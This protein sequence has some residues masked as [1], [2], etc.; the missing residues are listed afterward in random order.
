MEA[1]QGQCLHMA[2]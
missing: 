2:G 1:C